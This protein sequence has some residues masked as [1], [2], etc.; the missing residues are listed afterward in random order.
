MAGVAG[1]GTDT[2]INHLANS[3]LQVNPF[4]TGY[5]PAF[6]P[7]ITGAGP[8]DAGS[9]FN[10]LNAPLPT[11][12]APTYTPPA[13]YVAPEWDESKI[14]SLAQRK[15]APGLRAARSQIQQ[16]QGRYEENPNVK[17]MTLRQALAGYGLAVEQVLGGAETSAETE[18]GR[19]YATKQNESQ[20]NY[21]GDTTTAQTKY[22]GALAAANASFQAS[23]TQYQD[24]FQNYMK[25]RYGGPNATPAGTPGA[26]SGGKG[27]GTSVKWASSTPSA[28]PWAPG[29]AFNPGLPSWVTAPTAPTGQSYYLP[30]TR[31]D[32]NPEGGGG[33]I[34]Y[35]G[36]GSD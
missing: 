11:Y 36:G 27:G 26:G 22:Q 14:E 9:G 20:I 31:T 33:G 25:Q 21:Q 16:V 12:N 1:G 34:T 4:G 18:Y 15:A 3:G 23:L 35:E 7:T 29:G 5:Q 32:W 30:G 24:L 17:A 8:I 28:D 6:N 10:N 19:E 2:T 13:P